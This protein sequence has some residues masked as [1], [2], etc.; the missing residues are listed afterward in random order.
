MEINAV[1]LVTVDGPMRLHS[2]VPEGDA[3][4]AVIVIHEALGVTDYVEDVVRDFA[5]L[6]YHAVAPALFHRAGGGTALLGDFKT[7]AQLFEGLTDAGIVADLSA[8]IDH[9]H[10]QGFADESIGIVG[11]CWGGRVT[12]LAS[13]EFPLGAAVGFYGGGIVTPRFP[14]LSPLLERAG[15]LKTPWLGIFG[16]LDTV[17]PVED[18][19]T[20]RARLD[21]LDVPTEVLRY[22]TAEHGFH[23]RSR[24]SYNAEAATM[25]WQRTLD[26]L[27]RH[28]V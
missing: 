11:F 9:L 16:D 28:L 17:I 13:L 7:V 21:G 6:G 4:S 12:F 3:S 27:A 24:P 26:W 23:N 15:E 25:A 19:E 20:L 2:C 18:V 14:R 5:S 1:A 8:T 10:E 22:A